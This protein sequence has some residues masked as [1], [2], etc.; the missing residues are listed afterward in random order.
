MTTDLLTSLKTQLAEQ[1]ALVAAAGRNVE[2]LETAI[3]AIEGKRPA[4]HAAP[5]EDGHQPVPLG[6][7]RRGVLMRVALDCI[8]GGNGTPQDIKRAYLEQGIAISPNSVSN[9]LRRLQSSNAIRYVAHEKR[10]VL[11]DADEA[12]NRDRLLRELDESAQKLEG[13][14]VIALKPSERN[15]AASLHTAST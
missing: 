8:R 11:L 10:Y 1:Q 12:R 7:P 6:K 3:A 9:V 13:S 14:K 2:D 5:D 15:G 4:A